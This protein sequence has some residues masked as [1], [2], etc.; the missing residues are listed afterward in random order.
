[1]SLSPLL[2]L[3]LLVCSS[4]ASHF[5][6]TVM[7][8]IPKNNSA[9]GSVQVV[10]RYKLNFHSCTQE[11]TWV[12][13]SGDCGTVES[14]TL[15]IVDQ[16]SSG[17]W[18]Q[19]EG[20]MFRQISTNAPFQL[21]LNSGNWVS[22]ENGIA[23]WRALT[24]VDLRNRSDTG[25]ANRSPQT[26]ILP[27]LRSNEGSY[28]VQLVM[29]DFPNQNIVLTQTDGSETGRSTNE[30]LSSLPVQFVVKVDAPVPSCTE[31]HYLPRFLP[32]TPANRAQLYTPVRQTLSITINAEANNAIVSELLFSGPHNTENPTGSVAGQFILTWTP[33]EQEDGESHPICFVVQAVNN[34]QPN[35]I[36]YH[37]ALRC[38]I[39]RVGNGE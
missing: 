16:E 15:N 19:R 3:L 10:L 22:N 5:Y 13:I 32:P 36:K 2:L 21:R 17:E 37:S 29:E 24:L 33:S 9:D 6:G 4:H 34:R 20:V 23:A 1:M 18:C 31:G 35:P 39:V 28:V 8:F 30:A 27:A 25:Q 12:C 38:V 14:L 26:T 11:D 7:T